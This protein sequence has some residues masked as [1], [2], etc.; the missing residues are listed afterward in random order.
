MRVD[1]H[2]GEP[3]RRRIEGHPGPGDAEADDEQV[4]DPAVSRFG[5][6]ALAAGIPA[7]C[8]CRA[9]IC[10]EVSSQLCSTSSA[11]AT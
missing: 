9:A 2:D 1:G 8:A 10:A 4:D 11:P 3:T 7:G 5:Q 6:F